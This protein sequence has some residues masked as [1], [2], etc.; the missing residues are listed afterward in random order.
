MRD[1]LPFRARLPVG[2]CSLERGKMTREKCDTIGVDDNPIRVRSAWEGER[3]G[4]GFLTHGGSG[5]G[6]EKGMVSV[7]EG[8]G[9]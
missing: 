5:S 3:Y 6:R 9:E 8:K 7:R 1:F 4:F 2:G